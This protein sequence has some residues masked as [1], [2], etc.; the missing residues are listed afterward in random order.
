MRDA[1]SSGAC[2]D[3][4]VTH[5]RAPSGARPL[6][7]RVVWRAEMAHGARL[8]LRILLGFRPDFRNMPVAHDRLSAK[9]VRQRLAHAQICGICLAHRDTFNRVHDTNSVERVRCQTVSDAL[10]YQQA[11]VFNRKFEFQE[12]PPFNALIGT[13]R[14][15]GGILPSSH[16]RKIEPTH[17]RLAG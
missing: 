10:A 8:I 11:G 13:V 1:Q 3:P 7:D 14:V 4:K 5:F 15:G 17:P 9:P 12:R 2:S 16:A 6:R